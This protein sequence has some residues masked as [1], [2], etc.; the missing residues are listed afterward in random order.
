MVYLGLSKKRQVDVFVYCCMTG[1]RFDRNKLVLLFD[2]NLCFSLKSSLDRA[3]Y[4]SAFVVGIKYNFSQFFIK[5]YINS[6]YLLYFMI[7]SIKNI[8]RGYEMS[9]TEENLKTDLGHMHIEKRFFV[10]T[11][12]MKFCRKFVSVYIFDNDKI[13][14][15]MMSFSLN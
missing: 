13:L 3:K 9:T 5:L 7:I 6:R 12:W 15:D 11:Q 1:R 10:N 2:R 4:L 14:I 8:V